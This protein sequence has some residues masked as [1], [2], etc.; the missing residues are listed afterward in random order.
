MSERR[1]SDMAPSRISLAGLS[2]GQ[3]DLLCTVLT[4]SDVPHAVSDGELI[5]GAAHVA[6]VERALVWVRVDA[7]DENFD[8]PE[9]RGTHAPLVQPSRPPLADGRRQATRWR[10]ICGGVVDQILTTVP[11]IIAWQQDVPV[12]LLAAALFLATVPATALAGWSIGKLVVGTRVVAQNTLRSPGVL[13][14][15]AR[16]VVS[17]APVLVVMIADLSADLV[18]PLLLFVYAPIV[19]ALRG[20]HDYGAGTLVVERSPAGPGVF[21]RRAR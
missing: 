7:L 20:L 9:F 10:R 1:D 12:V 4:A 15:S 8:D 13:A 19:L 6:E 17:A 5:T 21:V 2:T 3:V 16:W 18:T 14:A 11:A